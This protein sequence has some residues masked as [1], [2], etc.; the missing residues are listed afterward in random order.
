M[1]NPTLPALFTGASR[2]VTC[3]AFAAAAQ[4]LAVQTVVLVQDTFTL[5]ETTR[6]EGGNLAGISHEQQNSAAT[7]LSEEFTSPDRTAT[8][9][10][11]SSA[12]YS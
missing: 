10:P 5:N 12:W 11:A 9:L 3:L 2:A 1:K 7:L 4:A 6:T 8:D